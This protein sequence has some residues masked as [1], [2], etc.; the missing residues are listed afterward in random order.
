MTF[1][2]DGSSLRHLEEE[3]SSTAMLFPRYCLIIFRIFP[4]PSLSLSLS[5]SLV[6]GE[7]EKFHSSEFWEG[8][9]AIRYL[10]PLAIA[11][12]GGLEGDLLDPRS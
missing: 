2:P 10:I 4:P 6:F 5:L 8:S 11:E 1:R 3:T 9:L 7:R 12:S